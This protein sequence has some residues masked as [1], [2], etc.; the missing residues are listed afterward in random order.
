M[1]KKKLLKWIVFCEML[2][3]KNTIFLSLYYNNWTCIGWVKK[4]MRNILS[5][6]NY[7]LFIF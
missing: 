5:I 2:H 3:S 7:D 6:I 4:S 1:Q